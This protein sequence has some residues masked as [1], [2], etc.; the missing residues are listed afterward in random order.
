[1]ELRPYAKNW[2]MEN[3]RHT[4]YGRKQKTDSCWHLWNNVGVPGCELVTVIK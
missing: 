3:Q 1:M 4:K 2:V